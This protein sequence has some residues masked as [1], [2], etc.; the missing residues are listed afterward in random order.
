MNRGAPKGIS[1]L[2]RF[3]DLLFV[4][5]CYCCGYVRLFT[6]RVCELRFLATVSSFQ[7]EHFFLFAIRFVVR[8]AS[9]VWHRWTE[10]NVCSELH[11]RTNNAWYWANIRSKHGAIIP[12]LRASVNFS[13]FLFIIYLFSS[14]SLSATNALPLA[15][16][17]IRSRVAWISHNNL[18]FWS[19]A[20]ALCRQTV[21]LVATTTNSQMTKIEMGDLALS[22]TI[23]AALRLF[24]LLHFFAL[25]CASAPLR[26][27]HGSVTVGA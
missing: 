2:F 9:F 19:D 10:K 11:A 7:W 23:G 4:G 26:A 3:I 14:I 17:S 5:C 13:A 20:T 22:T 25:A 6:L 16:E 24:Q 12:W 15:L 1:E 18:C 27:L 8:N 21:Q